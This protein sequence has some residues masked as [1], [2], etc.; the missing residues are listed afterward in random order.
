MS[1]MTQK[2]WTLY[3]KLIAVLLLGTWTD[4]LG[5]PVLEVKRS[6]TFLFEAQ[7]HIKYQPMRGLSLDSFVPFGD[8]IIGRA[9]TVSVT[10]FSD[11]APFAV[12]RVDV[13]SDPPEIEVVKDLG[14][15]LVKIPAGEFL[16]GSPADE[17]GRLS[18]EGPI[19]QVRLTTDFWM[20]EREITQAQYDSVVGAKP[21]EFRSP[22]LP[23]DSVSWLEAVGFC[24]ALTKQEREA[25]R[26]SGNERYRLPTEAEWEYACRAGSFRRFYFGDDPELA[27]IGGYAWFEENSDAITHEGG[28]LFPNG[29][30]LFDM[31]GNVAEW[32]SSYASD[33]YPGGNVIDPMGPSAGES[34]VFRGGSW[35]FDA[36]NCR[37]ASRGALSEDDANAAIGFRVVKEVGPEVELQ[38]VLVVDLLPEID[39]PNDTL[40]MRRVEPGVFLMGS[41]PSESHRGDDEGPHQVVRI[42][43]PFWLGTYEVTQRQYELVMA[44]NPSEFKGGQF[45]VESVTWNE[46]QEFCR[47]LTERERS[48]GNLGA[49]EVYR[50]PTEAEWEYACRAGTT[51]VFAFGDS[52]GSHQAN[53]NGT[54]PYGGAQDGPL[55]G[56]TVEVGRYMPNEWGFYDM[57]G[58]VWERCL[59]VYASTLSGG[60]D[61]RGPVSG[62]GAGER[63]SIRGGG[64]ANSGSSLRS[65]RRFGSSPGSRSDSTG[66]RVVRAIS[67]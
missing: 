22:E 9:G 37:S 18:D 15:R 48:A 25:G 38:D 50:L 52:L 41:L 14:L 6:V 53:F 59:D 42:S 55:I 27:E 61:P 62:G 34:R 16:M 2:S 13:I 7:P 11:D 17:E 51:T 58:N 67:L 23:V 54:K 57:H 66:F 40:Q 60:I 29:F 5:Q 1:D 12:F 47:R 33:G 28:Q 19:T 21:S 30:G 20:G 4:A 45:P 65:A 56:R 49:D 24:E 32:C 3:P 36:L 43:R 26:L 8:P 31:A 39:L 10:D 64:F 35:L 63:R 44:E 46:T